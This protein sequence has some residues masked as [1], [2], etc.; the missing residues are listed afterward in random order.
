[1]DKLQAD[2]NRSKI[3][4]FISG[5]RWQIIV[6]IVVV[7]ATV[8][9]NHIAE[10]LLSWV[11]AP[12]LLLGLVSYMPF[13]FRP[14][15]K[16]ATDSLGR[17][18][19]SITPTM[20]VLRFIG[21]VVSIIEISLLATH[22]FYF[23]AVTWIVTEICQHVTMYKVAKAIALKEA[24]PKPTISNKELAFQLTVIE[25]KIGCINEMLNQIEDKNSEE[26]KE[27][28]IEHDRAINEL[29]AIRK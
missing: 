9:D 19:D 10:L 11:Y 26:Y 24:K 28:L 1:M 27:M 12:M 16:L 13:V 17:M 6:L 15:E 3:Q 21:S 20:T 25:S 2:V 4:R 18:K 14:I 22:T 8:Y 29:M 23:L 5:I 7:Y